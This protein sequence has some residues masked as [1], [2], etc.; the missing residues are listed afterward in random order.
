ML[1][2]AFGDNAP[3]LEWFKRFEKGRM[4]VDDDERSG[5]PSAG[6]TTENVAKVREAILEDRRRTI[7]EVCD[8]VK[9]SY[10]TC[11]RI[12]SQELNMRRIAA[13]FVPRLLRK[14]Q[15]EHRFSTIMVMNIG[16]TDTTLGR[17][18]NNPNGSRQIYHDPTKHKF[19]TVSDQC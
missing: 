19:E 7:H 17:S 14:D 10:G 15:K 18:S 6:T 2:E 9:L 8:I 16:F 1:K 11:Q 5:R 4:S 3:N 13:K 12:L